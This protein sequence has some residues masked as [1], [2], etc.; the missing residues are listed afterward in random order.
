MKYFIALAVLLL[1]AGCA[2]ESPI[3]SE[4]AK[5]CDKE[6][7]AKVYTCGN[8]IRVVSSLLGGGSTYYREDGTEVHCPVVAPTAMSEEC[9]SLMFEKDCEEKEVC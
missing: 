7:V 6:N 4:A 1:L 2:S 3:E 8:H 5:Y 9:K